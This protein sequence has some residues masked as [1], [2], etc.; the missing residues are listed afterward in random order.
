MDII[1]RLCDPAA[2]RE[3]YEYKTDAAR[4]AIRESRQLLSFI[5]NEEYL[6][7][8][9]RVLCALSG[10]ELPLP[11]ISEISK[12]GTD[13]KRRVF[14]YPRAESNVFKLIGY[15]LYEYDYLIAD[16]VYSFRRGIGVRDAVGAVLS[17]P[18]LKGKY[19]YKADIHDYFNSVDTE[20]MISI[21]Q[22]RLGEAEPRLVSLLSAVLR[23]TGATFG[24]ERISVR[25]GI[26]PGV[27]ISGFLADL[28]LYEMD[29]W[30]AERGIAYLRYSDDIIVFADS[31][32]QLSQYESVIT[33]FFAEYGL[34]INERKVER[35]H[36]G[37][38]FEYLGFSFTGKVIDIGRVSF[39]KLKAKMRR[40][41][42]SL[43]RWKNRRA[44]PPERAARAF[45][46]HFN[47]KIF[48]NSDENELTWALWYFPIISTADTLEKIDAYAQE[49]IR[50]VWYGR[51]SKANY[52]LR[53][54]DLKRLGY[55]NLKNAYYKFKEQRGEGRWKSEE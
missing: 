23:D 5:E 25:R 13:K 41:A 15:L 35:T 44:E 7:P 14:V 29:T 30:F 32:Q 12:K 3:Y 38:S 8:A 20:R 51:H 48:D 34:E 27:A 6:A 39:E 54:A 19:T 17:V 21:L 24:G 42:H 52:R 46:K 53:Y 1:D 40:K 49:C 43:V 26:M 50:Y 45:I 37:E 33:R 9:E 4:F 22:S 11:H 10:G 2:W 55:R 31:E 36:P 16:N 47:K 28:Y 18:D